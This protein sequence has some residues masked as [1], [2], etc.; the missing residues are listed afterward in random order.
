MS[1]ADGAGAPVR[2]GPAGNG[3]PAGAILG[4][5]MYDVSD[6]QI[7]SL[8]ANRELLRRALSIAALE[9]AKGDEAGAVCR[10]ICWISD[11]DEQ[12]RRGAK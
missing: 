1:C 2:T 5:Q 7:R 4:G 12:I 11:A 10:V 9:A 6:S 8:L 3:K